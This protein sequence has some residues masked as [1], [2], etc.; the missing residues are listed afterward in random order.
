M[1][2]NPV[3]LSAYR[4]IFRNGTTKQVQQALWD[5]AEVEPSVTEE[6]MA[7]IIAMVRNRGMDDM[8]RELAWPIHKLLGKTHDMDLYRVADELGYLELSCA[9]SKVYLS[10][11]VNLFVNERF[12]HPKVE[13][14]VID[15]LYQRINYIEQAIRQEYLDTFPMGFQEELQYDKRLKSTDCFGSPLY[16]IGRILGALSAIGSS[17]GRESLLAMEYL[18]RPR[19]NDYLMIE[20]TR[21]TE[22]ETQA[23]RLPEQ[24]PKEGDIEGLVYVLAVI[25][26][27]PTVFHLRAILGRMGDIA[28]SGPPSKE[29]IQQS[30]TERT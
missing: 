21:T 8:S 29:T 3:E 7:S 17:K 10:G 20:R 16:P 19:L 5:I 11:K 26:D 24:N 28:R 2:M 13:P 4:M 18:F 25:L 6:L 27:S 30:G 14:M 1:K 22:G 12:Y 9:R 23:I 15:E